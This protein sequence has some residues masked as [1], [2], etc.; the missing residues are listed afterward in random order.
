MRKM[1]VSEC[2]NFARWNDDRINIRIKTILGRSNNTVFQDRYE[3]SV[4]EGAKLDEVHHICFL[5]RAV[6]YLILF[7]VAWYTAC[8]QPMDESSHSCT[9]DV[10]KDHLVI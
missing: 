4:C 1:I 8:V 6:L 9:F 10:F 3:K 7:L 5:R 2:D